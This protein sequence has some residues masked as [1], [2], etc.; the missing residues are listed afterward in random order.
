MSPPPM[1]IPTTE[2]HSFLSKTIIR[3]F[4][5]PT[6]KILERKAKSNH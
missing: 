2:M 6:P 5:P 4:P 1:I 3:K